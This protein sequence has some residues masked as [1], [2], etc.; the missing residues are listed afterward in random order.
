MFKMT[1]EQYKKIIRDLNIINSRLSNLNG[2]V[3][4]MK[5]KQKDSIILNDKV[6]QMDASNHIS[7]EIGSIQNKLTNNIIRSLK[8]KI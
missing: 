4:N 2:K 5:E 3:T 8:N 7:S 1:E 6:Y